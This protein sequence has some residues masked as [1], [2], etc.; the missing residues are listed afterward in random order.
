MSRLAE[1]ANNAPPVPEW[2]EATGLPPAPLSVSE[3]FGFERAK[4][5]FSAKGWRPPVKE[6]WADM[7]AYYK[8]LQAD[9]VIYRATVEE[10]RFFQWRA[11]YA[12]RMVEALGEVA[13]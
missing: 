7:A 4:P 13:A 12:R 1:F 3:K 10:L 2:F 6:E 11:H 8:Q 9:S 5:F